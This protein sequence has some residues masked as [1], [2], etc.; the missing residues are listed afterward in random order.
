L[1]VLSKQ[2]FK[3]NVHRANQ[4]PEGA[5]PGSLQTSIYVHRDRF[6]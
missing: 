3:V 5:I 6:C 4:A 2:P 1:P